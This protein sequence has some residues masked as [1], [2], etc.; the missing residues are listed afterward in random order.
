MTCLSDV[1]ILA[2]F[3]AS[4]TL[5]SRRQQNPLLLP[6]LKYPII[7]E[8]SLFVPQ[9]VRLLDR[10]PHS[11]PSREARPDVISTLFDDKNPPSL[12]FVPR[13][14][15][16]AVAV[17]GQR[18]TTFVRSYT[19]LRLV[20]SS[21]FDRLQFTPR[22]ARASSFVDHPRSAGLESRRFERTHQRLL[23]SLCRL[24]YHYTMMS[25]MIEDKYVP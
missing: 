25:D 17:K 16:L 7:C 1:S 3:P 22:P 15:A 14:C 10:Q 9:E 24:S 18:I 13:R 23:A 11:R 2:R 19:S 12:S 6:P 20:G 8:Y 21:L 4:T 5:H